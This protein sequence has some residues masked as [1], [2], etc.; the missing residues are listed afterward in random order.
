M[1]T[2]K[3]LW[4]GFSPASTTGQGL[5]G[6]KVCTYLK[7]LGHDLTYFTALTKQGEIEVNTIM[8]EPAYGLRLVG[9]AN[10]PWGQ[11]LHPY[12]IKRF[13]PDDIITLGD[14]WN[15]HWLLD[16]QKMGG[17]YR[18]IPHI[19]YDTENHIDMW[20]PLVFGSDLP[21][22]FAKFASGML[23]NLGVN[24][25]YIPHGV[26]TNTFRPVKY[27]EKLAIREEFGL[28]KE[29]TLGLFVGMN[30]IRKKL[31]R[32]IAA[33][34]ES[35]KY[36]PNNFLIMYSHPKGESGWDCIQI[37]KN[38]GVSDRIIWPKPMLD[39]AGCPPITEPELAKYYQ[40]SDYYVHL[41]GGAG[42]D[43][44]IIEAMAC[45]LPCITT[46]YCTGPE[47]LGERGV[48]DGRPVAESKRGYL[49]PFDTLEHH[50]TGGLWALAN[51]HQGA[52]AII[53]AVK[54]PERTGPMAAAGRRFVV[55]NYDWNTAVLPMWKKLVEGNVRYNNK[56]TPQEPKFITLN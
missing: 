29:A 16:K 42:F 3:I 38:Y 6:R 23:R 44:P 22:A 4:N 54:N 15:Y 51:I 48:K 2:K 19:T 33:F 53:E 17:D 9:F 10:S 20:N 34:A 49:I 40:A 28:P 41:N 12:L 11:D 52:L 1:E 47:F 43:I 13:K 56:R 45:Q 36:I 46:A 8:G 55:E 50:P 26:D 32:T 5:V 39:V 24:H 35:C 31:D 7:Q 37:A 14:I 25:E 30:Q 21:L 27:D 18:Y